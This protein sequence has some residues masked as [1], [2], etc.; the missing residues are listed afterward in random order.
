MNW[1][2]HNGGHALDLD[3]VNGAWIRTEGEGWVVWLRGISTLGESMCLGRIESVDLDDVDGAQRAAER[4]I[5]DALA[6]ACRAWGVDAGQME[7]AA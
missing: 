3:G 5:R 1:R 4:M 7:V 6:H 2:P